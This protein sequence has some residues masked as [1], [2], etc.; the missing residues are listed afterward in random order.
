MLRNFLDKKLSNKEAGNSLKKISN[1][2][3]CFLLK[4]PL[5]HGVRSLEKII[6]ASNYGTSEVFRLNHLPNESVLEGH[7]DGSKDEV[8]KVL[9]FISDQIEMSADNNDPIKL[10]YK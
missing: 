9:K 3:L 10:N 2:T 4:A 7:I 1:M 8:S 6:D 5:L